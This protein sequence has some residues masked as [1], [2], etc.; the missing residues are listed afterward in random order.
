MCSKSIETEAV[1]TKTI[2]NEM[3][4]VFKM[5]FSALIPATFFVVENNPIASLLIWYED[6]IL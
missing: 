1:F 3:L 4:D 2:M 6:T 5:V